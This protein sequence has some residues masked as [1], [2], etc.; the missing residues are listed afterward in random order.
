MKVSNIISS[1]KSPSTLCFNSRRNP[2]ASYQQMF[3]QDF[4]RNFSIDL[5]KNDSDGLFYDVLEEKSSLKH[6]LTFENYNFLKYD[7]DRVLSRIMRT[8][9]FSGKAFVEIVLSTNNEN[10]VVAISLV[11]FEPIL[12]IH[13]VKSNYFVAIQGDGKPR[14]FKIEKRNVVTFQLSKLGFKRYYLRR[15]YKRL[16]NFDILSTGDMSQSLQETG[17]DFTLWNNRREYK[18]LKASKKIGWH[19]RSTDNS[20]MGDAYLLYRA[21]QF[22][23][24]R[25]RCL[26]YFL[27]EINQSISV[28]CKEIGIDGTLIAKSIC[29]NYKELIQKLKSGKI[30]YSQLSNCVF[31]NK[32][33]LN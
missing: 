21:I 18:L 31:N 11:P 17:F 12:S 14:F 24:L 27:E 32:D 15:F 3:L 1:Q 29:Y 13:G 16:A 5:A 30:N 20:Y 23:S 26:D 4:C 22:K 33:I 6:L 28:A 25:K 19:G 10:N 7:M 9:V 8:L 2:I